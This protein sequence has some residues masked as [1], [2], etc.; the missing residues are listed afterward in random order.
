MGPDEGDTVGISVGSEMVGL[1]DGAEN[2][3]AALGVEEGI[4]DGAFVGSTLGRLVG[5]ETVG[6]KLGSNVGTT[7]LRTVTPRPALRVSSQ[8]V[9]RRQ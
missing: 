5:A 9:K 7:S 4:V 6:F 3:G 2:V 8:P 1:T